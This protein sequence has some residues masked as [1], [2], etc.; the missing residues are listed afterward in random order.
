M[1]KLGVHSR[2]ELEGVHNSLVFLVEE[3]IKW[4]PVDFIV[5]DGLRTKEEQLELV[6]NKASHTLDSKHLTG[7]AVD[8][9]P[10]IGGKARWEQTACERIAK[11]IWC[12]ATLH[13]IKLRWGAV[14][15]RPFLDLNP[16]E[17]HKEIANYVQ[18]QRDQGR[19]AFIDA[20][21]YELL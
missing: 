12:L 6:R 1:Y 10:W 8:L 9:V 15:D 19:R 20:V 21:H 14:W 11:T 16:N 3:I 4:T 18:R 2:A 7:K 13:N 17:L 5:F